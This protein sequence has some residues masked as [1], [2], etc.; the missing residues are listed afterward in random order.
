MLD[1]FVKIFYLFF[2]IMICIRSNAYA[3]IDPGTGSFIIQS[4]LAIGGAIVFYLGY[5][6]RFLKNIYNKIFKKKITSSK[7]EEDQIKKKTGL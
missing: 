6:I 5:P 1:K 7:S 4:I 3:Y 2:I